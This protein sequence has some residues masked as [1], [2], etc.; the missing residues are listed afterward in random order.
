V[1]LPRAY[2][3]VRDAGFDARIEKEQSCAAGEGRVEQVGVAAL[4]HPAVVRVHEGRDLSLALGDWA[5]S[6]RLHRVPGERV[7]IEVSQIA[8]AREPCRKRRFARAG[9]AEK[10]VAGHA[11]GKDV[12]WAQ[13][14]HAATVRSAR[15]PEHARCRTRRGAGQR[16]Q[17]DRQ[18]DASSPSAPPESGVVPAPK[19]DPDAEVESEA[20]DAALPHVDEL[21]TPA[22][23]DAALAQDRARL[24]VRL[25]DA[26]LR[27]RVFRY[28]VSRHQVPEDV[29]D[30]ITNDALLRACRA[31]KWP[32]EN[33]PIYPW[34]R[35]YANYQ[36][37]KYAAASAVHEAREMADENIELHAHE[38]PPQDERAADISRI[39]IELGSENDNNALTLEML[40]ANADGVPIVALAVDAGMGEEAAKKRMQRFSAAVRQRWAE[41]GSAVAV[42]FAVLLVIAHTRIPQPRPTPIGVQPER[43]LLPLPP[44]MQPQAMRNEAARLCNSGKTWQEFEACRAW[45]NRA[46]DVDPEGETTPEVQALRAKIDDGLEG[47]TLHR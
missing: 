42:A 34:V 4:D 9:V 22:V 20:G 23:V 33:V 13:A 21:P 35:R 8:S 41:L 30:D 10:D 2:A 19:G 25:N 26:K 37:L 18:R 38:P 29:A 46:R 39:A 16:D 5:P 47:K 14:S 7:K 3:G 12:I 36:R 44:P 43:P 17:R 31:R 40:R 27:R 11:S 45:L 32:A 1:R 6:R 28:L 15:F 24:H